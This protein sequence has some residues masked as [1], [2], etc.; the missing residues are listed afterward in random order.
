VLVADSTR[1]R[2]ELGW[3][4]VRSDLETMLNGAWEW[5]QNNPNGY[6]K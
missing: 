4:P 1:A 5:L 2:T 3:N 6:R